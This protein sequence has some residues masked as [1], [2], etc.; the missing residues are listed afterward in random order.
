MWIL[1]W[2]LGHVELSVKWGLY[3]VGLFYLRSGVFIEMH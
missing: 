3:E 1:E 2:C